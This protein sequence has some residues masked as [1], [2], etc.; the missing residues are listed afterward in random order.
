[1]SPIDFCARE[2]KPQPHFYREAIFGDTGTRYKVWM[3]M[4]SERLELS[5]T[6]EN[7]DDGKERLSRQVLNRLRRAKETQAT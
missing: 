4:G 1:M 2:K 5:T 3:E 6:F 7:L